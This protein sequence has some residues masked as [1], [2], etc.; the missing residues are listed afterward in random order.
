[1]HQGSSVPAYNYAENE[2]ETEEILLLNIRREPPP[3]AFSALSYPD[4]YT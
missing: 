4:V 3:D 1:V 2:F